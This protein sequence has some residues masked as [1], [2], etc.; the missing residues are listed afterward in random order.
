MLPEQE[1]LT[2]ATCLTAI[3]P[4]GPSQHA[5]YFGMFL[6]FLATNPIPGGFKFDGEQ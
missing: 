6:P 4:M 3:R 1:S 2:L 5:N